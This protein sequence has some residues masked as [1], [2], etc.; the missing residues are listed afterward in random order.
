MK[1]RKYWINRGETCRV[2]GCNKPARVKGMCK[3]A[4]ENYFDE[5]AYKELKDK[6]KEERASYR[7]ALKEY[8]NKL[9]A[10]NE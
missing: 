9:G 10:K 1:N 7:Q 5:D 2:M 6:E 8:V 3:E 4:I